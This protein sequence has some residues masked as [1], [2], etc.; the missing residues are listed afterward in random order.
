M[1]KGLKAIKPGKKIGS[2]I[3]DD[4]LYSSE[5]TSPKLYKRVS[6]EFKM[7]VGG[8]I[9]FYIDH[10]IGYSPIVFMYMN[11]TISLFNGPTFGSYPMDSWGYVD[12]RFIFASSNKTNIRIDVQSGVAGKIYKYM[13]FIF[14]EAAKNE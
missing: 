5:F 12:N 4:Y 2:K 11:P 7:P 14:V 10:D 6:G 8:S 1:T 3:N 9:T 13:C